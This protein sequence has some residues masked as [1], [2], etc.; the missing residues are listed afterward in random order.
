ML[1][2]IWKTIL[3]WFV[4]LSSDSAAIDAEAPKAAAAVAAAR[5]SLAVD[6]P[7]P[8]PPAPSPKPTPSGCKCGCVRGKIKPD[9]RIEIPCECSPACTCKAARCEGGNCTR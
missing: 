4:W 6:A 9:G 7:S 2:G 3:A 1:S 8:T 5:A